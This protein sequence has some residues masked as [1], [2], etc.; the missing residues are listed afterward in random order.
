V[1]SFNVFHHS[2]GFGMI[3]DSFAALSG[4]VVNFDNGPPS[5]LGVG[6]APFQV[7]LRAFAIGLVFGGN[8]YPDADVFTSVVSNQDGRFVHGTILL[9]DL[10]HAMEKHLKARK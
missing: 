5:D 4:E 7:M 6:A 2:F 9:C 10:L 8:S 1:T 3:H